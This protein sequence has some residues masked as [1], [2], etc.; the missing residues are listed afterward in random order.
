MIRKAFAPANWRAPSTGTAGHLSPVG[1][2]RAFLAGIHLSIRAK[3]LLALAIV[4]LMMGLINAVLLVQMLSYSRQYDAIINNITTA[5][6]ISGNIKPEIDTAM[7]NIVAG[8]TEFTQG[9]Q[10]DIING[11]NGKLQKIGSRSGKSWSES[12]AI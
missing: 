9:K 2:F 1:R 8:K 11:V 3:I 7:W 12:E 6:S 10:Y 4:I 5:N